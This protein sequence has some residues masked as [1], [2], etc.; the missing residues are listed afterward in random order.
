MG[1]ASK[2][3]NALRHSINDVHDIERR[4]V[5]AT[6]LMRLDAK[7]RARELLADL[8][9]A[10]ANAKSVADIE[11]LRTEFSEKIHQVHAELNDVGAHL[12]THASKAWEETNGF[13]HNHPWTILGMVAT[14]SL[15]LGAISKRN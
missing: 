5:H 2:L 7:Y 11:A 3:K 14:F 10:P 9:Q 8:D 12:R 4:S 13:V 15:I 6:H 1:I